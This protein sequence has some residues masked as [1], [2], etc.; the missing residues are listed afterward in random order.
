[1]F[2]GA[3]HVYA[4]FTYGM[5]T[6]LNVVCG[7]P[8]TASALLIRA[9]EVVAGHE[10]ATERRR[11]GVVGR[12]IATRDLARGPA[13]LAQALGVVLA[14]SGTPLAASDGTDGDRLRLDVRPPIAPTAIASGPRVG[15]AG[16]GG[17]AKTYPWRFWIAG[18]SFVSLYR[19]AVT[20]GR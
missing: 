6:C 18:D 20:R 14:D 16:P 2:L 8:G 13:R 1:M 3:G 11:G 17:D 7:V 4:Y 12:R 10:L 19:P 5:H 15:V 9:G